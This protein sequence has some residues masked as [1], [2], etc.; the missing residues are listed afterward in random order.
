MQGVRQP[1]CKNPLQSPLAFRRLQC[2]ITDLVSVLPGGKIFLLAS[3]A[4]LTP[5]DHKKR[6]RLRKDELLS[7]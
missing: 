3:V 1:D 6:L 4:F 7:L 2:T 5:S